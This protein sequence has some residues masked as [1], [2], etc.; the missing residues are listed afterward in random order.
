MLTVAVTG[1]ALAL[2]LVT[3]VLIARLLAP[4]GRG[5]LAA[6]LAAPP[7]LAWLFEMGCGAAVTYHHARHPED[8][9]RL[10]STW[11]LLFVPLGIAGICVGEIVLPHLL[12][13]QSA[14]TLF[15]ARLMMV[16]VLFVY[17]GDLM[18]GIVL[19]DRDF[20]FYNLLRFVQP[21]GVALSYTLLW[22]AGALTVATAVAAT[23][24]MTAFVVGV[25][26]ARVI[27]RHGLSRP[28][29]ALA[30]RTLW[31]GIRA[32]STS[33]AGIVNT[34]LDL[35]IIPAFLTA[36][37][38]GLYSVATN[39]S[40]MVVTVSGSL[41]G[42]VFPAAAARGLEGRYT[43]IKSM[44]ATLALAGAMAVVI[45]AAAS[46]AVRVV[47]GASFDGSVAPLRI[48]LVG[49]VFYAAA[50]V[51]FAG[52]YALNRPFTAAIAQISAAVV[53]VVG[54]L[55]FLRR[56]GIAAAATVSTVAYCVVFL[57]TLVF[58]RRAAGLRWGDLVLR[59]S[60]MWGLLRQA[61]HGASGRA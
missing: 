25:L 58:Y 50:G 5:A 1:V 42:I 20:A 48:L 8:G 23:A 22:V 37:S 12:A 24:G 45:A 31:F 16:S 17:V 11:L 57:L 56:D 60:L 7:I 18:Y 55:V 53:T 33:T 14:H 15:L 4:A 47:Y 3:G 28:S 32:H 34:R 13:A 35:L 39:V 41:A 43:V 46:I 40:W 59:P 19:A 52:L 29:R 44:Y 21:L 61:A 10:I 36:T 26:S 30:R 51:L 27:R 2:N 49:A 9:G 38:V 54:L 6:A